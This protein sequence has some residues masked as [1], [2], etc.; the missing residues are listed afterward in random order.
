MTG[1]PA[2][3]IDRLT[4]RYGARVG[5]D[6]ISFEVPKGE[7]FGYL[8]P[9][10]AGKTTT[11]RTLLDLIRPSSGSAT[12]LG[13]DTRRDSAEIRRRIGFVPGDVALYERMTGGQMIEYLGN[14]RG[15]VDRTVSNG[16][17]ERLGLDLS[18]RID[19]LSHG[20]RQKVALVQ[21]FMHEPELVI[22][23]EPTQGLDPLVQHEF[24]RLL[25]ELRRD[26]RTVFLSSHMLPEVERVCTRVAII[27]EGRLVEVADVADLTARA[28]R[29]LEIR[30]AD[31]APLEALRSAAGVQDLEVVGETVRCRVVGNMDAVVKV[32]AQHPVVDLVSEKPSLEEIFLTFYGE[33]GRAP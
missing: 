14:L 4:K 17:A 26:G 27:R 29:T 16:L 8:G 5:I 19:H 23:D 32:I 7:V 22:L 31:A 18:V 3:A 20:N 12:M 21:A 24:Y 2:I 9:N 25:D 10:G 30:F 28:I 33:D 1:G 11:I 15:G 13:L 6:G